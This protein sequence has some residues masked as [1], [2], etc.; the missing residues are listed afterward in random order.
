MKT[1]NKK[2]FKDYDIRGIYPTDLNKETAFIIGK[3]FATFLNVKEIAVGRDMRLSGKELFDSFTQGILETGT[4][5]IN[6]GLITTDMLYFATGKY[7]FGGGAVITASHN[8]SEWNGFKL[9]KSGAVA[10]SKDTGIK[11]IEKITLSKKFK[12]AKRKGKIIKK[13]IYPDWI[14]HIFSFIDEKKLK[15]LKIVV[16]AGNGMAGKIIP[17]IKPRLPG[18]IIPLYFKLDGS[19]PHHIPSPLEAKNLVDL[20]KKIKETQASLGM[21]FDG[22]ADRVFLVDDK[23]EIISGTIMTAM[24]A[25]MLL[26]NNKGAT[27]LYN[28]ICGRIVPQTIQKYG[29]KSK[30][31]RVGHTYIKQYM[32]DEDALFAGEHSGH[33]YFKENYYADS[34]IIAALIVLELISSEGKKLSQIKKEFDIYPASGEINFEVEDIPEII[35]SVKNKFQTAKSID[36]IDGVSVWYNNYWFN[37]RAS[38]TEPLLR[39]NLEADNQKILAEKTK[40]VIS[41]LESQGAKRKT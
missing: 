36:E 32:R 15:P 3:A 18:K 6:L 26:K 41:L 5:V 13:N 25:K 40:E 14:N 31:V 34:G 39:L 22:D 16:D 20:Q 1:I 19:F 17:L 24:V 27:I 28:A 8:P 2:I 37:I 33:Y 12:T 4:N 30:R 23:A 10:I 35:Q 7:R 38:K 9:S 29:G 11:Q 21:A